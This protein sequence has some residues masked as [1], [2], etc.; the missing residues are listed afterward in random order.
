[1]PRRRVRP[2]VNRPIAF[3]LALLLAG[4]GGEPAAPAAGAEAP[5]TAAEAGGAGAEPIA[6]LP[7]GSLEA[8]ALEVG[9]ALDADGRVAAVSERVRPGD[10]VHASLV[11]VGESEAAMLAIAWRDASGAEIDA[12]ERAITASGPAVH[13][14]TRKPESGWAPGRY[15]VE[16]RVDG[17]SAGVRS[18]EVR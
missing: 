17:E 14:F 9:V 18:F 13:T 12:D 5:S 7:Q 11:T 1:M 15:E 4:C 16:V 10:A 8:V 3:A 2:L 6:Q